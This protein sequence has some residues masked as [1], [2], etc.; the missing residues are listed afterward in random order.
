[1]TQRLDEDDDAEAVAMFPKLKYH[2]PSRCCSS[3][4]ALQRYQNEPYSSLMHWPS[5]A[6]AAAAQRV[7]LLDVLCAP[8]LPSSALLCPPL[9]S[10]ALLSPLSPPL[11]FKC[12]TCPGKNTQQPSL[13]C[14]AT[15]YCMCSSSSPC[16][17]LPCCLPVCPSVVQAPPLLLQGQAQPTRCTTCCQIASVRSLRCRCCVKSS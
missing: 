3:C 14:W 2:A 7:R 15:P 13:A 4:C 9:P 17:L 5:Q 8:P 11:P 10:S 1:M 16:L 6:A 12:C